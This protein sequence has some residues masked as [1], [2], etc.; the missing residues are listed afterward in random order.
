VTDVRRPREAKPR[1]HYDVREQRLRC[2]LLFYYCE[3]PH[4]E[5]AACAV[6]RASHEAERQQAYASSY[7]F[8]SGRGRNFRDFLLHVY[9]YPQRFTR[10]A[11]RRIILR[12]PRQWRL[13]SGLKGDQDMQWTTPQ[14]TDLRF[15]FEITMYIA[16]R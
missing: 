3:Q 4:K 13:T 16:N 7:R 10:R 14:F 2:F 11:N 9:P 5:E 8:S 15:G 6:Q 12:R 1:T